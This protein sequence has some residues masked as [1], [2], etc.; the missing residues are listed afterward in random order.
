MITV[1]EAAPIAVPPSK[2]GGLLRRRREQ[3]A[4]SVRDVARRIGISPSYLVA[5]EQGRNP[6]TGRPAVPSPPIVA[7]IGRTLD[8]ELSV[9]LELV[10][11]PT[12]RSAHQLLY[13]LGHVQRSPLHAARRLFAGQVDVW[14]E[15]TDPRRDAG[16]QEMPDD[17]IARQ[18]GPLGSPDADGSRF[19]SPTLVAEVADLIARTPH[20]GAARRLG[21]VCGAN[22][23]LLRAIDN[24]QSLFDCETTWEDD[25]AAQCRPVLGG[26]PAANICVY[27]D[28]DVQELATRLDPLAAVVGLLLA[29]PRVAV[30]DAD[31]T[32][33][34]GPAAIETILAGVRPA[35]VT[36][37]TWESLARA[38]AIGFS[39]DAGHPSTTPM[40]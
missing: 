11:A 34:T 31:G 13:Q 36:A 1:P 28:G 5:L 19:D 6:T 27:H 17:V 38:A 16:G 4:L 2:L 21:I 25:L 22:S 12:E 24:P 33:V 10:G 35:G 23:A 30:E 7:A 32:V 9:L 26:E 18:R 15:V 37:Q 3:L 29:H 20:A 14:I 8:I 39:R 40:T